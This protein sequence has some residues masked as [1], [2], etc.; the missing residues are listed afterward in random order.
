M[1]GEA[2]M[3]VCEGAGE[4]TYRDLVSAVA[5]MKSVLVAF[6]GGVDSSLVLAA[7]VDA[8]GD[9]VL[10]VTAHSP[11][12][13]ESEKGVAGSIAAFLGARHIFIETSE[14]DD[15]SYRA[16]PPDRCYFCKRALFLKLREMAAAGGL[17]AVIDGEN[18]D[19]RGDYRPGRRATAEL[20]IRSPLAELGIGKAEVRRLARERGLPNWSSPACACLASRIPYGQ[21]ITRDR[22]FRIGRA[23][24]GI[25]ALGFKVVRVRD[26]GALARI[27][28]GSGEIGLALDDAIRNRLGDLCRS[29]GYTYVCLDLD[30]YRTGS[31]NETIIGGRD[32]PAGR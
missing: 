20:G 2:E 25:M 5:G 30:G 26:Y 24:A 11:T 16:N 3:P 13:T 19:D 7:A 14:L 15:P 27:E 1:T 31:M 12:Y 23:E 10:A 28:V 17:G 32:R 9:R 22:L 6:S 8:L 21:E 29:C 4:K 18:A